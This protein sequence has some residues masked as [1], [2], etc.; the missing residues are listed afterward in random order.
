MTTSTLQLLQ[1]IAVDS[2]VVAPLEDNQIEA[3]DDGLHIDMQQEAL[4]CIV[5]S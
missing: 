4:C 1:P 3:Y 2:T 5:K